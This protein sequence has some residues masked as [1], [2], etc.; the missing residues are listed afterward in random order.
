[1]AMYFCLVLIISDNQYLMNPSPNERSTVVPTDS[2]VLENTTQQ[3]IHDIEGDQ[4]YVCS[5]PHP[6]VALEAHPFILASEDC[7]YQSELPE[8]ESDDEEMPGQSGPTFLTLPLEIRTE[9]YRYFSNPECEAVRKTRDSLL[10]LSRRVSI[11]CSPMFFREMTFRMHSKVWRG[12]N[13]K[14]FEEE[15]LEHLPAYKLHNIRKL[16]YY[17]DGALPFGTSHNSR[18][19]RVL[20]RILLKYNGLF[21]SLEEIAI[22][23]AH[24]LDFEE[25]PEGIDPL[26]D[27]DADKM[28]RHICLLEP[29]WKAAEDGLIQNNCL[30]Q[31]WQIKR[32]MATDGNYVYTEFV[33]PDELGIVER[34]FFKRPEVFFIR[35]TYSRPNNGQTSTS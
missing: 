29:S 17:T 28:W 14:D 8:L 24:R 26:N 12:A 32:E 6:D 34:V 18:H 35:S 15:F 23:T 20:R 27:G 2:T 13:V 4:I 30:L 21:K 33:P 5:S 19:L 11:E 25:L 3:H 7:E 1:M 31:D 9:I 22:A 16:I 10:M